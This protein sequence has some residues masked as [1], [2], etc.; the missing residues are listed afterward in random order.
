M[1][2]QWWLVPGTRVFEFGIRYKNSLN[3]KNYTN[4][5]YVK[6]LQITLIGKLC[7]YLSSMKNYNKS[8]QLLYIKG[9]GILDTQSLIKRIK[10]KVTK[11]ERLELIPNGV[12]LYS[13]KGLC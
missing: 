11:S 5:N 4:A 9:G 13:F 3:V 10:Y 1:E 8:L 12:H 6:S 2:W 7:T